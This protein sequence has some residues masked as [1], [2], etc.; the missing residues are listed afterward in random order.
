LS[1]KFSDPAV[2]RDFF[3]PGGWRE[4]PR[5]KA[6]NLR[7]TMRPHKLVAS[8][9]SPWFRSASSLGIS[10]SL[11]LLAA[12]SRHGGSAE[13]PDPLDS[14]TSI[15]WDSAAGTGGRPSR[16]SVN[17]AAPLPGNDVDARRRA[18]ADAK[19]SAKAD[20]STG[21]AREPRPT[22]TAKYTNPVIDSDFADP[23]VIH[24]A[25]GAYYAYATQGPWGSIQV[26]RSQDLVHWTRAGDAL[27]PKPAWANS[28]QNFW[29]PHVS[30]AAGTYYLYFASDQNGH[31]SDKCIGVA[32]SQ[33]PVGPFQATAQPLMCA[34]GFEAIDPMLFDDEKSGK[35]FLYWGSAGKP[36]RVRELA[37]DR[38][39]FA[40][41]STAAVVLSPSN[42]PYEPLIEGPWVT[43]RDGYYYLFYS[44]NDC[45]TLPD[46]PYAVMVARATSPTGPFEKRADALNLPDSTI[47]RANARFKGPGH[48]AVIR[49][50]RGVDWLAY[51]AADA[52][53]L[54]GNG[55]GI[56]RPMLL[57]RLDYVNGWPAIA[58]AA[59]STAEQTGPSV[60]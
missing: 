12:C 2:A 11:W 50:A 39:S 30:I 38:V 58:G 47:L 53:R 27:N 49:D 13:R 18:A 4:Q 37:A 52:N 26:G 19:T 29:A 60:D 1:T 57:D 15:R 6:D 10:S 46:P 22:T 31:G 51:H 59:P 54:T 33:T 56:R 32:T 44:G 9:R 8:G 45:C 48:N 23:A 14:S 40:A 43:A 16:I 25:D 41:G 7:N 24:A 36:L 5:R 20:S 35:H 21:D 42:K 55:G 3:D 17:D 34:P 28:T